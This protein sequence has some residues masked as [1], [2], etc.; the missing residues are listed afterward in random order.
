[1]ASHVQCSNLTA[2]LQDIIIYWDI[3]MPDRHKHSGALYCLS[4]CL[5]YLLLQVEA[6]GNDLSAEAQAAGC[7]Y[8]LLLGFV[9]SVDA[10]NILKRRKDKA[11]AVYLGCDADMKLVGL[12]WGPDTSANIRASFCTDPVSAPLQPAGSPAS[13]QDDLAAAPVEPPASNNPAWRKALFKQIGGLVQQQALELQLP[14]DEAYGLLRGRKLHLRIP[15]TFMLD[16][17]AL[18][19]FLGL[20]RCLPGHIEAC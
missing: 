15:L 18:L 11:T 14:D 16:Q 5:D 6:T 17:P 9:L 4:I 12:A 1:M 10:L 7:D 20:S 19:A 13:A 8:Q 3:M 2:L